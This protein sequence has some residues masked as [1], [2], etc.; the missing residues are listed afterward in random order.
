[1]IQPARLYELAESRTPV[2]VY[3]GMDTPFQRIVVT[4]ILRCGEPQDWLVGGYAEDSTE[5]QNAFVGFLFENH[6]DFCKQLVECVYPNPFNVWD[7]EP[8][9]RDSILAAIQAEIAYR[10][11]QPPSWDFL[12]PFIKPTDE[13]TTKE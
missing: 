10:P 2:Y 4:R 5:P 9:T 12:R 7:A 1:M 6:G 8:N 3:R 13:P 11:D